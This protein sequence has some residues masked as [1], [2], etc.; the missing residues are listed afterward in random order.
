[1][2]D[3]LACRTKYYKKYAFFYKGINFV[4]NLHFTIYDITFAL[5]SA[6]N[7]HTVPQKSGSRDF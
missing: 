7:L 1:M 4:D 3:I 6:R 2:D 5:I